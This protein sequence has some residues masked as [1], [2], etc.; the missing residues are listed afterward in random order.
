MH[1]NDYISFWTKPFHC[2]ENDEMRLS[3]V[4]WNEFIKVNTVIFRI[5]FLVCVSDGDAMIAPNVLLASAT[6]EFITTFEGSKL[7]HLW[8]IW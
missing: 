8:E 1:T 5:I 6:I 3:Y 2:W 4:F 7:V